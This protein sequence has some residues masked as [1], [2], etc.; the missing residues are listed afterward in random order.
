MIK[1]KLSL[2]KIL[3]KDKKL[4]FYWFNDKESIKYKL[5]TTNK[6][7]FNSHTIWFNKNLF[8]RKSVIWIIKINKQ[9][10]GQ[11][12]FSY[13]T[14]Y[15]YEIDI[16]LSKEY[17]GRG[18]A[19]NALKKAETFLEKKT[20]VIATVKKNNINSYKFFKKNSFFLTQDN[21]NYWKLNKIIR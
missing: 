4:L 17:R 13:I 9:L 18:I 21:K 19:S 16:F 7:S 1:E 2:R 14:N 11:I 3:K 10:I 6:I 5:R 8:N 12:R 15:S 20:E